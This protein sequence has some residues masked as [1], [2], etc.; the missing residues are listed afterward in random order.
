MGL[1]ICPNHILFDWDVEVYYHRNVYHISRRWIKYK[2]WVSTGINH[3]SETDSTLPFIYF[4]SQHIEVV[5]ICTR[6]MWLEI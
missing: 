4:F 1:I 2:I 3:V 6:I 5:L